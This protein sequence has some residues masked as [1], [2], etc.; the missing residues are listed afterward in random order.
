MQKTISWSE[1]FSCSWNIVD[2]FG[3][4]NIKF[5]LKPN[6]EFLLVFGYNFLTK[7]FFMRV[8]LP[9]LS[10]ITFKK[11]WIPLM[12]DLVRVTY[13]TVVLTL[14]EIREKPLKKL[15]LECSKATVAIQYANPQSKKISC[16]YNVLYI[17]S[18]F[19]QFNQWK[20][21]C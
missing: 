19:D 12:T 17:Q 8:N 20:L 13:C 4:K 9:F 1:L 3:C 6:N 5:Q 14:W 7:T 21:L 10:R 11:L 2:Y 15:V 16:L 18:V